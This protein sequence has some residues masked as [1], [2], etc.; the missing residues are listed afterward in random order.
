MIKPN[1]KFTQHKDPGVFQPGT[2]PFHLSKTAWFWEPGHPIS[3]HDLTTEGAGWVT[4]KVVIVFL[5]QHHRTILEANSMNECFIRFFWTFDRWNDN[6]DLWNNFF[7]SEVNWRLDWWATLRW[8][9]SGL[10]NLEK[11][12]GVGLCHWVPA[13]WKLLENHWWHHITIEALQCLKSH[14]KTV[15]MCPTIDRLSRNE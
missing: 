11:S 15:K 9:S 4:K 1:W 12:Q 13:H 10:K 5:S 14:L 6:D 3:A 2:Q 7:A 8:W